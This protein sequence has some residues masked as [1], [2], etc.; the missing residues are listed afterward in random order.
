M[1]LLVGLPACEDRNGGVDPP[2]R[3]LFFPSGLLLD[4]RA[5]PDQPARYLF[6]ANGNN[7][8]GYN[9]GTVVAIDLEAF[10]ASWSRPDEYAVDPYCDDSVVACS[11][12]VE[13]VDDVPCPNAM[14]CVDGQCVGEARCVL[15]VGS[16]VSNALPCR[17]LAL[18][19]QV[20]EC[21]ESPFIVASQRI[22]DFATL[23]THSCESTATDAPDAGCA[24]PRLWLPVRGDP[25]LTFLDIESDI[26][27]APRFDCIAFE[28][29]EDEAV[30]DKAVKAAAKEDKTLEC[31]SNH[32]LRHLRNETDLAELPREPFNMVVSP[33]SRLAYVSHSD[34]VGLSLVDLDGIDDG[35]GEKTG[36]ALID[37]AVVF[38]D[39]SGTTGGFGLAERPCNPEQSPPSITLDCARPL[40]YAGFRY[41]RLLAS[42]TV[43]GVEFDDPQDKADQC[44]K[45]NELGDKGKINCDEK[46]RSQRLIFPGGLDPSSTGFRPLLGDIAFAD[47]AGDE[48][49]VLQTGPG[50][51]LKLDTHVGPDGEPIDSPSVPPLELCDEPSRMKLFEDNGQRFALVSCFRAALIYVVDLQGF[52]VIDTIVAGTGPYELEVD[53]A[54]KL[55]YLANNLEGSITIVDLSRERPTRFRE[56][57]RIGLQE[58]F[59]R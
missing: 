13:D 57:A 46:V 28:G 53:K 5:A 44:A 51:L 18:L 10:F 27:G 19:P 22:G 15:D 39:P 55:L 43:Q 17:R 2:A 6:V 48:L 58:P 45:T 38:R 34:G 11:V 23:L 40:V 12:G 31:T 32:R 26:Y 50:A 29:D 49:L 41:S 14:P 1:G 30:E 52:R 36:P 16:P 7:D 54:R 20:V 24:S 35:S 25:S 21:D 33:T 8:L 47:D 42:F 3:E 9:A 4:P 59:S 56:I 37:F